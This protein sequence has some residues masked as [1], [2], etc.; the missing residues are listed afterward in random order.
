MIEGVAEEEQFLAEAE[1][2]RRRDFT[3]LEMPGYASGAPQL[4]SRR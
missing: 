2:T 4:N 1:R 3:D